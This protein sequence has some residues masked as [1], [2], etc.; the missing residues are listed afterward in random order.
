MDYIIVDCSPVSV[1]TDAEVWMNVVD[2]VLLVVR[3]DCADIRTIND[4]VDAIWQNGK[5]FSGFILNAFHREWLWGISERGY[6]SYSY[7]SIH[8]GNEENI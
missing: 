5:D 3:E 1:S 2:S 4:V 6:H 8:A 7:G